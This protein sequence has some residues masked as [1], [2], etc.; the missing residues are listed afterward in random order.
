MYA[1]DIA[2]A[3]EQMWKKKMFW[4]IL[5]ISDTCKSESFFEK[6]SYQRTPN[7]VY[8][9]SSNKDTNSLSDGWSSTLNVFTSDQF[10]NMINEFLNKGKF[11]DEF[12]KATIW[13][14]VD[15]SW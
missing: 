7:A 3:V 6:F 5:F 11:F 13:D 1:D 4:K 15:F 9:T 10:T 8:M 12:S 2:D 14:F